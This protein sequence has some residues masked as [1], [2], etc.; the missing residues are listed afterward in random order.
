MLGIITVT[1]RVKL[2]HKLPYV[3]TSGQNIQKLCNLFK[4][5]TELGLNDNSTNEMS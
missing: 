5:S 4:K 1:Y 2:L 3:S